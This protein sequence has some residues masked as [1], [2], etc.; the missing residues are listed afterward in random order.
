MVG[1]DTAYP[2]KLAKEARDRLFKG[3]VGLKE[4]AKTIS[5]LSENASFYALSRPI[6]MTEKAS[7]QLGSEGTELLRE[8]RSVLET[9]DTWSDEAL[10]AT[11]KEFAE[12]GGRKLGAVAQPIRAALTGSTVSP[13]VFE[14]MD[15]LG[16]EETLG[17][18]DD[19]LTGP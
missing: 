3:M 15:V 14:I 9:A 6:Q 5:E 17:R 10:M 19:A 4:R 16:R 13:S 11:A 2:G 12:T 18:I 1:M 8:L 7:Q